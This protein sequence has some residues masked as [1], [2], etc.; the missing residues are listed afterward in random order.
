MN[1]HCECCQVEDASVLARRVPGYGDPTYLCDM[2]RE[3]A[4]G[5]MDARWVA[6]LWRD[7][8]MTNGL[9]VRLTHIVLR[10]IRER[11][12]REGK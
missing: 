7:K 8:P 1:H 6:R 3:V 12:E 10:A 9:A 5:S 4:E 2:C 11:L